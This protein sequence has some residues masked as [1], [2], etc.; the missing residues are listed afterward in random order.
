MYRNRRRVLMVA[1]LGAAIA[2]VF[3]AGV[4]NRMSPYGTDDPATQSVQATNRFQIATGARW[5]PGSSRSSRAETF[6]V[7]PLAG[8]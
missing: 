3:G 8:G 7:P 1:V 6:A 4:A 2:A 5:I